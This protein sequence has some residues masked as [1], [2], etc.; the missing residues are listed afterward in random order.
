M[1]L[2]NYD[3]NNI[4]LFEFKGLEDESEKNYIKSMLF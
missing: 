4:V 1:Y 2:I 3:D